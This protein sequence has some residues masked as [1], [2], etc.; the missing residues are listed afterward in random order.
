MVVRKRY[1][2]NVVGNMYSIYVV[3]FDKVKKGSKHDHCHVLTVS[4]NVA[5]KL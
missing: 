4:L 5:V 3:G 2:V 1:I